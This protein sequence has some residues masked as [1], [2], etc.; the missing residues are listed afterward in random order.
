MDEKSFGYR[1]LDMFLQ[2][3]EVDVNRFL[4]VSLKVCNALY[5]IHRQNI[6]LGN[7]SPSSIVMNQ[8]GTICIMDIAPNQVKN[9]GLYKAPEQM[10]KTDQ[11][12]TRS[13][14]IYAL[15]IIFYEMLSGKALDDASD[16][17]AF[18]HT[19][20]TRNLPSLCAIDATI[21][22]ILSNI[23]E[24]MV[25]K[26]PSERYGEIVSVVADLTKVYRLLATHQSLDEFELDTVRD[27]L[28]MNVAEMF[29]GREV[30]EKILSDLIDSHDTANTLV[31][32][33]GSSGVGKSTLINRVLNQ[34]QDR[35]S[36]LIELKF[37]KYQQNSP[38]EILYATLRNLT[39]QIIAQEKIPLK[40]V[41]EK[42]QSVLGTQAQ[43][44]ID[45]I[46]EIEIIIGKQEK[47]DEIGSI[48]IKARF[49]NLLLRFMKAVVDPDKKLAI[50]L[51]DVQW[52][53]TVALKWI[54]EI[55]INLENSV[56]FITY[57]ENEVSDAHPVK[58]MIEKLRSYRF[59]IQEFSIEP[60]SQESI[61][62]LL[63]N[64]M[65]FKE[66]EAMAQI[67]RQKT[68]GNPFFIK[69]YLKHLQK[70]DAVWFDIESSQWH[71]NIEKVRKQ[72][73]SDNVFDILAAQ[74]HSLPDEVRTLLE[75]ASCI[76]SRFSE[77]ILKKTINTD[78]AFESAIETAIK[79]E[80][81]IPESRDE[82]RAV[83]EYRFSHD[84]M[85]E[86]IYSN[87]SENR[88]KQIHRDIGYAIVAT[89]DPLENKNLIHCVNQLNLGF[90]L[91]ENDEEKEF[92]ARLNDKASFHAK[93]SGDFTNALKYMQN[94]MRLFP[95]LR[96]HPDYVRI[97][98]ERAE[99]EHLCH[100]DDEAI[101]YYKQAIASSGS[102]RQKGEIY[103][104]MIKFYSDIADFQKAYETGK[105]AA[106]L[107]GLTIP[108]T[109][110]P[111]QFIIRFIAL[112]IKLRGYRTEELINLPVSQDDEFKILIRLLANTLQA[113][114]QIR[115][116]LCVANAV[117]LVTLC[118]EKGLTKEAVI[119]FSVFGVI[120]QGAIL[121][122]HTLGYEYNKLS[123]EM[124]KKFNNTTQHAEV[125]FVCNYFSTS[126]K[127]P[128]INAEENWTEAYENALEIG[129]WFH[130]GCAAAGIV[131]S[132]FMRG[133]PFLSILNTIEHFEVVLKNIGAHEQYGAILSVKQAIKNLQGQTVSPVEFESD[134]FD[135]SRF[136]ESLNRYK[137]LHFAHYYFVNKM[138]SLYIQK[139]YHKALEASRSGEKFAKSSQGMLHDTEHQFYHALIMAQLFSD[140][141]K[142]KRI[143][144]KRKLTQT[145]NKFFAWADGCPE[146]FLA[147][148]YILQGE[149]FRMEHN[150]INALKS[151][152]SG[153]Q[154]AKMYRQP[155]LQAIA[156]RL[157]AQMCEALNLSTA[158]KKYTREA[159]DNLGKWG[160][161]VTIKNDGV[162]S[163][164]FDLTTLIK[165][166][167]VIAKE[168]GLPNLLRT[169]I[170]ILIENAGAQHGFL[171]LHHEGEWRVEAN[172]SVDETGISVLQ[173]RPYG[174]CEGIV[175]P[176]VNYVLKTHEVVIIDR[177]NENQ[178]FNA[179]KEITREVQSVLCAPIMLHGVL[180]EIIYLEN[181]LVPSVFT[182]EKVEFLKHLSGQIAISIENATIYNTLEEKIIQRTQELEEQK[183]KAEEATKAKS[184]FLA[185]MSHEIRTPMNG[186]IGMAHLAL[187]TPLNEKQRNFVQKIDD[188][189]KS[190]LGIINDILDFS[191][192]EAGKLTIEKTA[193]NLFGV[194]DRIINLIEFK[195]HEKNIELIVSYGNE[196]G[197]MFYGDSLRITQVLT[198]L[199][200]NALK[201]TESGEIGLYVSKVCEN[202]YRFEVKDTGIGL[203]DEQQGKLFQ[204]FS[205]ADGS[206]TRKYGGTGLGLN[207]SKQ[208]V[209]LMGGR[210]WVES[211]LGTGS[212]FVFEIEL[213][214][215]D[216][217][218]QDFTLFGD[219]KVL[220]VDDNQSWHEILEN[221]LTMFHI[222]VEHA[223]SAHEAIQRAYECEGAF[224]LIL[225]DWNMPKI[226]GIEAAKMLSGMC[227]GCSKKSV[228]T[229][230]LPPTV[231]MISSFRQESIVQSAKEV[232]ID[233]FLQKPINP[234]LLNDILSGLFLEDVKHNSLSQI[235]NYS[236]QE[237]LQRLNG[238]KI[239]LVEDNA[240]NQEIIIGLLEFSSIA[241]DIANNGQEAVDLFDKNRYDLILM[242]M[243]M[244]IMDGYEATKKIRESDTTIPIIALSANAM[245]EEIEKAK[246]AGTN[247]HI[248]KPI[249]VEKLYETLLKY[250]AIPAA[251]NR[252]IGD[253]EEII[254]TLT[255][256][257]TVFGLKHM[258]ENK[259]LYRKVLNDFAHNYRSFSCDISDEESF[260][261]TI[262]TLKGLSASIGALDV[263]TIAR[264]IEETRDRGLVSKL[265]IKVEEV[266]AELSDT[267]PGIEQAKPA[268]KEPISPS[269]KNG[270]F[271]TLKE[272]V[273]TKRPK[274]CEPIVEEIELYSLPKEDA[275]LFEEVKRLIKKYRFK[276]AEELLKERR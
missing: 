257:D 272:A 235:Q 211:T 66:A 233:I 69:Q 68:N 200:S 156:N 120:F 81:I 114:Y 143:G 12:L 11:S 134:D 7:L 168:Q 124:L 108:R 221:T 24:K 28:D 144:D 72:P 166:S 161:D 91:L 42:L 203:S 107:F 25:S 248:D 51:D 250:I 267:L 264:E 192:I 39:K 55:M 78:E 212:R 179:T 49:D 208:L 122:N 169:L 9:S 275:N 178:I 215:R 137:S 252:Q 273:A 271:H 230:K 276:E 131:Q 3:S 191:K 59:N 154:A 142:I 56:V 111:P 195:A 232:G 19:L 98:K 266:V 265:Y 186:I 95:D 43:I 165:A 20:L 254:P 13:V 148:A 14:D 92:L 231:V 70:E 76:G 152:E 103:E 90:E 164:T 219:K 243:Q 226:D 181:N 222:N 227:D 147:R 153:I 155:H 258:G 157:A 130:A 139:E 85:Q 274:K 199:M 135:E 37:E 71:C 238:S 263:Y 89:F 33:A 216:S 121:G 80:W 35:F 175:H 101:R 247:E 270:L 116:E 53:D 160:V 41:K 104:L 133:A 239:L 158:A 86:S 96:S 119:G 38:Y 198:N 224:D 46:P 10:T 145:K 151:Y 125:K 32:V 123:Y 30:E 150:V 87:I 141:K 27:V 129:D 236:I 159:L 128:S 163:V 48:D 162:Q 189:A 2:K 22:A 16:L 6:V 84:R 15:G 205:Q 77:E 115:P 188:S 253:S 117:I 82:T 54:E 26:N 29:Y 136:V 210:I 268:T 1:R 21:P 52:I 99:C 229:R 194:V 106:E 193:F 34:K 140:E 260:D 36:H 64:K 217:G 269:V 110:I 246:T 197:K 88:V 234:S 261:R 63:S 23:I 62:K 177:F 249:N 167:E 187:Q 100:N 206:T 18:S 182:D 209:E 132:M 74:I 83:Q 225:M 47:I 127:L 171:L 93:K 184:E 8:D 102:K 4:D 202:R 105:T 118:L 146:N 183:Q 40:V 113:A 240:I 259:K 149:L 17:L 173:H 73:I 60:L 237:D 244:P 196:I 45:V 245:H 242:D 172:A 97:L 220:I 176:I 204:S 228:C 218:E 256:V 44:L 251:A 67:I 214:P 31:S 201:F 94:A 223:Y 180:K 5:A 57:R 174:E 79:E 170:Q 75:I 58:G 138:I 50:F 126:W 241:I 61:E 255:T 262:H 207:I 65:V 213:E 185:N 112:K 109:F 190:L